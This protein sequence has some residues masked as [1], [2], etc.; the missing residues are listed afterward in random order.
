MPLSFY[1]KYQDPPSKPKIEVFIQNDGKGAMYN[2]IRMSNSI[3]VVVVKLNHKIRVSCE[4]ESKKSILSFPTRISI[5]RNGKYIDS[6]KKY[7]N[8]VDILASR[9]EN[10]VMYECEAQNSIG[11]ETSHRISLDIHCK[12][13]LVLSFHQKRF[14][15]PR[16]FVLVRDLENRIIKMS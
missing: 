6:P 7:T 15:C 1:A 5:K 12:F 2:P 4:V 10:G 11:S 13:H 14:E 9:R 3:E 16:N 8:S